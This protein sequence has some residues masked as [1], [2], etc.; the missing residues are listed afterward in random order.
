VLK[1]APHKNDADDGKAKD[2]PAD[3]PVGTMDRFTK[4]LKTV[5]AVSKQR[6]NAPPQHHG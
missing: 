2:V 3:D 4:G 5:L 6:T 1:K